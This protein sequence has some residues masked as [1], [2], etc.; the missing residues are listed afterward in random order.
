MFSFAPICF[1]LTLSVVSSIAES[2][3]P[4]STYSIVAR[5]SVTGELGVAVQSH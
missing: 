3:R 2:L 4:V 5:D 1:V